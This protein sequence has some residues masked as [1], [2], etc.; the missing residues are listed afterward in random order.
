MQM[1]QIRYF[2]ALCQ[3]RSFTQAA[4]RSGVSQPSLTNAI[5]A[6]EQELG[7]PLFQRRPKVTLTALGQAVSPYFA[8]IAESADRAEEAAR[9]LAQPHTTQPGGALSSEAG[10]PHHPAS[11]GT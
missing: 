9:T 11:I 1:H 10:N 7:G 8:R 5:A 4:K 3:E 6:L 2:L